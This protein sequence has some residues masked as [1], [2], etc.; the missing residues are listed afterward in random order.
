MLL[1]AR[2]VSGLGILATIAL[3]I[4]GCGSAVRDG[5]TSTNATAGCAGII[6]KDPTDPGGH[7]QIIE[8]RNVGCAVARSVVRA[9]FRKRSLHGFRCI[10]HD[11]P[12]VGRC[13]DGPRLIRF[14]AD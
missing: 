9:Y 5:A 14:V 4:V 8:A 12:T 2:L 10:W 1:R 11:T 7:A 3:L 6:S 13:S